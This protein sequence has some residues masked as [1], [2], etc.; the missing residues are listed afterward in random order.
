[1]PCIICYSLNEESLLELDSLTPQNRRMGS[2]GSKIDSEV[3]LRLLTLTMTTCKSVTI[4]LE[5]M[6]SRPLEWKSILL[7]YDILMTGFLPRRLDWSSYD[8]M[9]LTNWCDQ[10]SLTNYWQLIDL[11]IY[12]KMSVQMSVCLLVCGGPMEIQTPAP[13]WIKFCTHIHT[14][15][16]KV[17]VQVWPSPPSP[18]G[19]GGV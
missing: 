8:K 11:S 12:I 10:T 18:L 17:L 7:T 19:P 14:C 6:W 2:K 4:Q 15:L 13:I 5:S 9:D 3:F 1:M 16:G